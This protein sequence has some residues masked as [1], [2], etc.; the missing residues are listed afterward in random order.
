MA[1]IPQK[2]MIRQLYQAVIGIPENPEDNGLIGEVKGIHR[3]LD[4]VNGKTRKNE[5]RSKV[6][7]WA[8]GTGGTGALG[9][10]AKVLG[11]F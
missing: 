9:I 6:N 1:E 7:Q 5:I 11:W 8:I 4:L 3:K 10:L 2:E